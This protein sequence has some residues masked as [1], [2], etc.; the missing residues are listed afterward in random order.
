MGDR[1][2]RAAC[3]G[4]PY[5]LCSGSK[6]AIPELLYVASVAEYLS[7]KAASK[8]PEP[9]TSQQTIRVIR[10]WKLPTY[11]DGAATLKTFATE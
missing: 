7:P 4:G 3:A 10:E 9:A 2:D 5:F 8:G 6:N 11:L 1:S